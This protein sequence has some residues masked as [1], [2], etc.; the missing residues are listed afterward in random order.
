MKNI[1]NTIILFLFFLGNYGCGDLNLNPQSQGSSEAW[2][3]SNDEMRMSLDYLYTLT[4]WNSNPDYTYFDNGGWLDAW[5]DD[6]HNRDLLN[7]I[8]NG[9]LNGQTSYVV[10]FWTRYY[11]CIAQANVIIEKVIEKK[12][13]FNENISNQYLAEARF[14]RARMY[15]WLVF[16]YGDVP[17]YEGTITTEEAFAMGR[18][19][20]SEILPKIYEDFDFAASI[21]PTSWSGTKYATKGAALALKA[22]IALWMGDY[23]TAH[24]AAKACID[25]N[26]YQLYPDF[27]EMGLTKNG[28]NTEIIFS[29]PRS[30]ELENYPRAENARQRSPRTTGGNAFI[31]PS[32]DLFCSFLCADGLPIDESPLY[33]PRKPFENRDPRC[34]ATIVEHGTPFGGVIWEPHPDSLM[35]TKVPSG[36]RVS[37]RESSGVDQWAPWNGI[38]WRKGYDEDWFDDFLVA[39]EQVEIRFADVLLIYA[40]AKIELNDIDQ[41]VLD[42]MNRVRARAYKINYTETLSYPAITATDQNT[43][44]KILRI[45]RR[46]EFAF[47]GLRYPD[48]LRWRLAEKALNKP[49]YGMLLVDDLRTKVVNANLWFFPGTPEIDEDG[50]PDF[51][52]MYDQGLIRR[53]ALRNFDASRNYLWPIPS[54]EIQINKNMKQNPGY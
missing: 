43:L 44:R 7:A 21:L 48:L 12:D 11:K 27:F 29:I 25:L 47:E 42:A 53:I 17:Y 18:T 33:N 16:L 20:T 30:V 41:T 50:I 1:I 54:T 19:A 31:W 14:V 4:F 52:P 32:W 3:S 38:M 26:E 2:Y 39:P 28:G 24:D 37:N 34:S 36:E 35:C 15:S 13:L 40:E 10:N 6:W 23:S 9:T 8:T 22:R 46:M 51:A 49:T 5:S 45:E